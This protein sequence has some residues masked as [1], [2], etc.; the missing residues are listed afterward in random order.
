MI[1]SH[2]CI[3]NNFIVLLALFCA[4]AKV[5]AF[6][7]PEDFGAKGDKVTDDT[8]A[9]EKAVATGEDILIEGVY[10]TDIILLKPNQALIGKKGCELLYNYV[11][12]AE[13][14][15]LSG[16][17]FDGQWNTRG[18]VVLGSNVQ[19]ESCSFMNTKGSLAYYGGLT[20]ALRIGTYQDLD[21]DRLLY[22]DI[23]IKNC[24]FD[25]C[26]PYDNQSNISA[27]KT[28][29]RCI[30]S[31]GCDNLL[32]NGC[33]FR[34]LEGYYDAD[35]IQIRSFELKKQEFPFYDINEKWTAPSQPFH[36]YCYAPA[37]TKITKCL[38]YQSDCK[39]SVKIMA[40]NAIV[41]N[42][43]FIV[44]NRD[45]GCAYSIVRA[46]LVCNV[47]VSKNRII[48]LKGNLDKVFEMGHNDGTTFSN[49][50]VSVS[51]SFNLRTFAEMTYSKDCHFTRNIIKVN[52]LSGLF[53]SEFNRSV[54]IHKN[55]FI[56]GELSS[57]T[58]R[59]FSRF[60]NHYSYPSNIPGKTDF[61]GNQLFVPTINTVTIDL[62]NKYDYPIAFD[63][64]K[65]KTN[66]KNSRIL[67]K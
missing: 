47:T 42:N 2:R 41:E 60:S 25:G 32:I 9:F 50:N 29:A 12:V 6:V 56:F 37:K 64:N 59:M 15:H 23:S 24:F 39:S 35:F 26:K 40:S 10:K 8:Q 22:H 13:G 58:I 54:N 5:A 63:K 4:S 52:S 46:Y 38:F 61:K 51:D 31:Y 1:L 33:T 3:L 44:T 16:V 62:T 45:E 20:S 57:D 48:L 7:R 36:S 11:E 14:C 27:N 28:V 49:N 34:N 19:I 53:T 18:V 17:V 67:I 30:L 65:V 66:N 21:E 55:S 43:T